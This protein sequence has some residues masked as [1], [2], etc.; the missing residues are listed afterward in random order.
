MSEFNGI[1]EDVTKANLEKLVGFFMSYCFTR[2]FKA[3]K[4][5]N[6]GFNGKLS[7]SG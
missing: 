1:L 3:K 4:Q 5:K 2:L 7:Y 6:R